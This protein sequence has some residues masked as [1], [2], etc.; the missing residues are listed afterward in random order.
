MVSYEDNA[1]WSCWGYYVERVD[2]EENIIERGKKRDRVLIVLFEILDL[3]EFEVY[4][5]ILF[6]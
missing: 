2:I 4:F 6:I 5:D 1:K 3:V